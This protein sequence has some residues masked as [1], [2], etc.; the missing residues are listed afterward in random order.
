MIGGQFVGWSGL[1]DLVLFDKYV[2]E[3]W[4]GME[5]CLTDGFF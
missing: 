3:W 5:V 1:C 4:F 2:Y